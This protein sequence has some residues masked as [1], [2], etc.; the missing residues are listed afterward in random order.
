MEKQSAVSGR[1]QRKELKAEDI[2][3]KIE[4]LKI[5]DAI[6]VFGGGAVSNLKSQIFNPQF[7]FKQIPAFHD[8]RRTMTGLS[9]FQLSISNFQCLSPARLLD[10]KYRIPVHGLRMIAQHFQ[11]IAD[12]VRGRE[13]VHG[14]TLGGGTSRARVTALLHLADAF[15]TQRATAH[16]KH[17][18]PV[19]TLD[20]DSPLEVEEPLVGLAGPFSPL[21][22]ITD[23]LDEV[24]DGRLGVLTYETLA[25]RHRWIVRRAGHALAVAIASVHAFHANPLRHQDIRCRKPAKIVKA[26]LPEDAL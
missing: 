4:D 19:V 10:K 26:V 20:E 17:E 13:Q 23:G 8:H 5:T 11:R 21:F 12:T 9:N 18:G 25:L 15:L 24:E 2:G 7:S 3:L 1:Q 6:A 16:Q 22:T 14:Q